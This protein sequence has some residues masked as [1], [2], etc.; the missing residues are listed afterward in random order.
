MPLRQRAALSVAV[1][2]LTV[3]GPIV[4]WLHLG[5]N[6]AF[7]YFAPDAF[8]YLQIAD[9]AA[10]TGLHAFDGVRT[11]TG[12]HPLWGFLLGAA[13]RHVPSLQAKDAQMLF[14]LGLSS[15]LTAIGLG[16]IAFAFSR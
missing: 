5:T 15:V 13:F 3:Y 12:F 10:R 9:Q 6:A 16:L 1:S 8:Y 2:L 4:A 7:L 11:T 14:T